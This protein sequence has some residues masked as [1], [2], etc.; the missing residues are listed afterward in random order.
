MARYILHY[1]GVDK[2][3]VTVT[4][5]LWTSSYSSLFRQMSAKKI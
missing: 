1:S 3:S 2:N 4:E 5:F